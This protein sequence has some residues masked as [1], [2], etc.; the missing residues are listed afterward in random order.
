MPLVSQAHVGHS[1]SFTLES[2]ALVIPWMLVDMLRIEFNLGILTKQH[3]KLL[4]P[5][6]RTRFSLSL[7]KGLSPIPP[8]LSQYLLSGLLRKAAGPCGSVSLVDVYGTLLASRIFVPSEIKSLDPRHLS[9]HSFRRNVDSGAMPLPIFTALQHSGYCQLPNCL[10]RMGKDLSSCANIFYSN[11]S[12]F[13]RGTEDQK[14][15]GDCSCD[16]SRS[17][18]RA[19]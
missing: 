15:N 8:L 11:P 5:R 17:G 4:L 18:E 12:I 7:S 3:S 1:V 16:T 10:V 2:L 9:L 6:Q 19:G 13:Y 14:G